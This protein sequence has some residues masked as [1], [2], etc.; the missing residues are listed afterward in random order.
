M[1]RDKKDI[2]K[3]G[4]GSATGAPQSLPQSLGDVFNSHYDEILNY[5]RGK[6]GAGPPDP[7]DITQQTFANFA[8]HGDRAS[9]RNPVG[10]LVR[11]AGNLIIDHARKSGTRLNVS[12]NGDDFDFI[13]GARDE[14]SPEIVVLSRERFDCV[15][16]ALAQLPR[17]QRRFVLL[18]RLEGLSY[19]D[20]AR[21]NG[22]SES[23]ARR[24]VE[25]GVAYCRRALNELMNDDA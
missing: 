23:T 17:R 11:I 25:A 18:N 21:Q 8:A 13:A 20:I 15:I 19:T 24:E 10:F 1:V 3:K 9:I 6:V 4:P 16:A 22:V 14:I 2:A 7:D 12:A 5:V